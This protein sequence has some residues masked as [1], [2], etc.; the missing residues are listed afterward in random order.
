MHPPTHPLQQ[1]NL[2]RKA[3]L[4]GYLPIES[5]SLGFRVS[6]LQYCSP[7]LISY[8]QHSVFWTSSLSLIIFSKIG[9]TALRFLLA[10]SEFVHIS[11]KGTQISSPFGR[12]GSITSAPFKRWRIKNISS[13]PV[14]HIMR[15]AGETIYSNT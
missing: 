7:K 5:R 1:K 12:R 2:I 9:L 3:S 6:T 14:L 8:I 15:T 11:C 13:L 4:K 10:N